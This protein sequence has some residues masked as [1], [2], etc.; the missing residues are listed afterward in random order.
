LYA[1]Q[2]TWLLNIKNVGIYQL[3]VFTLA[4]EVYDSCGYPEVNILYKWSVIATT[5]H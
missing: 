2:T 3:Q 4:L 1:K 5:L